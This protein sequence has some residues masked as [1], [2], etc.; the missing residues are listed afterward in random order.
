MKYI[1]QLPYIGNVENTC[2]DDLTQA[3]YCEEGVSASDYIAQHKKKNLHILTWEELYP[4]IKEFNQSLCEE[5]K[6][7][8]EEQYEDALEC[9]PPMRWHNIGYKTSVFF[10]SEAYTADIHSAY[11][12]SQG[13]Y[14]TA[15]RSINMKSEDIYNDFVKQ[16]KTPQ[17]H[18]V[19]ELMDADFE[20]AEAVDIV[21]CSNKGLIRQSL[22]KELNQYI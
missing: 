13:K 18:R 2:S 1:T 17:C 8:T 7:I 4:H 6:E 14:Y 10:I 3:H 21:L 5:W 19:L 11:I 15:N 22:E 12:S 20:Y 9:L 16:I